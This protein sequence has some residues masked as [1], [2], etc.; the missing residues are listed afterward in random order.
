MSP[1]VRWLLAIVIALVLIFVIVGFGFF[2]V[3]A[4]AF[5]S[6]SCSEI[7]SG[8]SAALL[9]GSPVVMILGVIA[10]AI[11]FGL[12]KRWQLWT[13]SLAVSAALGIC[14][15]VSWFMFISQLCG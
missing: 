10:A 12:N 2:S 14:G 13:G 11:L 8:A 7:G 15:Y 5:G 9:F 3:M 6:D 1:I 4:M